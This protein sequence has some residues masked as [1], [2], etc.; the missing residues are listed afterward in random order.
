MALV[1]CFSR[2][3]VSHEDGGVFLSSPSLAALHAAVLGASSRPASVERGFCPRARVL[4]LGA[5]EAVMGVQ[6]SRPGPGAVLRSLGSCPQKTLTS[7][8]NAGLATASYC[9]WSQCPKSSVSS[10]QVIFRPNT[11]PPLPSAA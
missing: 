11:I 3:R 10:F 9:G 1:L 6:P 2:L 7:L 8:Q 5:Q 4:E